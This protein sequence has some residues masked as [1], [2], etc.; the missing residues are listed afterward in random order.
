VEVDREKV[1]DSPPYDPKMTGD[2]PFNDQSHRY[3]GLTLL[4]GDELRELKIGR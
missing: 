3:F 2:G 1:K 4:D